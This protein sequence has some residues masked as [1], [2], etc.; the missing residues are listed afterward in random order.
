MKLFANPRS[1]GYGLDGLKNCDYA[2]YLCSSYSVE[3]RLQ[4]ENRI[5][6]GTITRSK[7]IIDITCKGTCEQRVV[8][9]LKLGKEL[10]DC[11][12]TDISLFTYGD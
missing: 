3:E 8:E 11:G 7:Y 10:V 2:V 5:Y 4:S 12:T 9:A 1:A 6:R